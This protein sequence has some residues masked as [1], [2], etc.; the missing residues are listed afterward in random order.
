[1][2]RVL[3]TFALGLFLGTIVLLSGCGGGG[4]EKKGSPPPNAAELEKSG[5]KLPN[6]N[7]PAG[8]Q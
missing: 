6:P 7:L 5:G 4:G 2:Q 3:A 1:M 8:K